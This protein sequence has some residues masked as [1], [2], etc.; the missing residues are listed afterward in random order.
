MPFRLTA[1]QPRLVEND[2]ERQCLDIM[3]VRGYWPIRLHAGTFK[4]VDGERWIKGVQKG[5]PDYG[6]M[7]E[8]YP[9]FLL[10]T[11]RPGGSLTLIQSAAIN[12]LRMGYRLAVCVTDGA[13]GFAQWLDQHEAAARQRWAKTL[14]P[15]AP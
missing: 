7:H 4:S 5:T 11:K 9:G 15:R 8:L 2:V 1:P 3:L 10:E 14:T 13:A 12:G 6:A